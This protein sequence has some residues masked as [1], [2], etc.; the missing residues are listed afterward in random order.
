MVETNIGGGGGGG[1][2]IA[3]KRT[4]SLIAL[5][6]GTR[7]T[8]FLGQFGFEGGGQSDFG[9]SILCVVCRLLGVFPFNV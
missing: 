6:L 9:V 1:G 5:C 3:S 4:Y 2:F 7:L 8:F